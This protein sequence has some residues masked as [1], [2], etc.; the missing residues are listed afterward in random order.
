MWV[1]LELNTE[2]VESAYRH[3]I[4]PMA[5]DARD[6]FTWHRPDPRAILPLDGFH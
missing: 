1:T 4:F 5:I 6:I 2:M 3:G